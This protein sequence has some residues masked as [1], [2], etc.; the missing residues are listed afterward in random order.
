M[1]RPEEVTIRRDVI[2][3]LVTEAKR[4]IRTNGG[5]GKSEPLVAALDAAVRA[6]A[7][8]DL[9]AELETALPVPVAPEEDL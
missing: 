4:K 1:S 5:P 6:L 9:R 2:E 3:T 7:G 8:A